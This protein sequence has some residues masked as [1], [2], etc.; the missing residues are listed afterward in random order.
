M[1]APYP[2]TVS[3][4]KVKF[5]ELA[6]NTDAAIAFAIEEAGGSVDSTWLSYYATLAQSYLAAHILMVQQST[7]ESAAGLQVVQ[8]TMGEISV[9]YEPRQ[10]PTEAMP[11]EL[12]TTPYGVR[13][14]ELA[15]MNFGTG[16]LAI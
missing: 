16:V 12:E 13:F 14:L 1:P 7:S 3:S 4:M 8:E 5:P 6:G 2:P 10:Q 15:R 9:R 11:G